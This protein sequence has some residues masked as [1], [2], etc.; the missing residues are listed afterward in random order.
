MLHNE[1]TATIFSRSFLS[2]FNI[3]MTISQGKF[4][5]LYKGLISLCF[6]IITH[7]Y[8]IR[9]ALNTHSYVWNCC[10]CKINKIININKSQS[11]QAK[12]PIFIYISFSDV[13]LCS[14]IEFN[15]YFWETCCILMYS[16]TIRLIRDKKH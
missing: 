4:Y 13:L 10:L 15:F 7:W 11:V 8:L 2:Q 1:V 9:L 6:D 12:T 16:Y 5:C 14:L 3:I